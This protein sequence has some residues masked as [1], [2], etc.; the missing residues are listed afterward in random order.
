ME[1]TPLDVR[2]VEF[3]S[4]MRGYDTE[5]VNTFLEALANTLEKQIKD[6]IILN[7]Q[8]REANEQLKEYREIEKSLRDVLIIAQRT[9]EELVI[10]A[11]QEA[12]EIINEA[13]HHSE[14]LRQSTLEHISQ[15]TYQV[16]ELQNTRNI[17][18]QKFYSLI[19]SHIDLINNPKTPALEFSEL[20]ENTELYLQQIQ[21]LLKS[22]KKVLDW[23]IEKVANENT[24]SN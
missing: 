12:N 18:L 23:E 10:K 4:K 20:K 17:Y 16:S 9:A 1:I 14:K 13:E 22:H 24:N 2:K 21:N 3:T 15:L 6:N 19:R 5:E 8:L 7:D 11:R